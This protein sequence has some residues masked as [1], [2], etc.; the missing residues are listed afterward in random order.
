MLIM[1]DTAEPRPYFTYRSGPDLDSSHDLTSV[2]CRFVA[3]ADRRVEPRLRWT[4]IDAL[5]SSLRGRD[6]MQVEININTI[7]T[8]T[9]FEVRA[10]RNAPLF[11]DAD[12]T[13][14]AH[15]DLYDET[16]ATVHTVG[17]AA[18]EE[19]LMPVEQPPVAA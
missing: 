6:G 10:R 9:I 1:A 15:A 13:A 8:R 19:A 5:R 16:V 17:R 12:E 14:R 3:S 18:V 2:T 7:P 11:A 4:I